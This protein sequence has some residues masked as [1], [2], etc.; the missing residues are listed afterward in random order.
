MRKMP[1][2]ETNYFS[3]NYTKNRRT[4][5]EKT[6]KMKTFFKS[7]SDGKKNIKLLGI[8]KYSTSFQIMKT[9]QQYQIPHSIT[10]FSQPRAFT[11]HVS[12]CSIIPQNSLNMKMTR[13]IKKI[14][15]SKLISKTAKC[16]PIP[17]YI[18]KVKDFTTQTVAGRL[19]PC[20]DK[21]N[22]DRSLIIKDFMDIPNAYLF[23]VLDGH[24]KNGH[25]VSQ[26]VKM[27]LPEYIDQAISK[28]IGIGEKEIEVL[29]CFTK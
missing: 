8:H 25:I 17:L 21:I 29:L 24:G 22:Q 10:E 20:I 19:N 27:V 9:F 6:S 1:T 13:N 15:K 14:P 11:S 28:I 2:E 12:Q 7:E 16:V 23:A 26:F 18:F 5:M 4:N 3:C